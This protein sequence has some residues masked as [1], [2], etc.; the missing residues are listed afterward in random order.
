MRKR[1]LSWK[2][3]YLVSLL[4]HLAVFA[5]LIALLSGAVL[6]TQQ[7]MVVVDLD[8][9]DMP[10]TAG[11][12]H[13]GGGNGG[14]RSPESLFPEKLSDEE[15][16]RRVEQVE[17][18]ESAIRPHAPVAENASAGMPQPAPAQPAGKTVGTAETGSAGDGSGTPDGQGSG[19]GN[20]T[21]EG[22]G[23]GADSGAGNGYGAG[24]GEGQGSGDSGAQGTGRGSFDVAG[25]RAA[26]DANKQYPAMAIRRGLTG[27]VTIAVTLGPSGSC[28]GVSVV[29]SSGQRILDRAAVQAARDACPYP[30]P[31]GRPVQVTTTIHFSLE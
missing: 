13:A 1:V 7:R 11:S 18:A 27:S 23:S 15:M 8:A 24:S 3:A 12:G 14:A 21:S 9:A 25:F 19:A 16:T 22:N 4:I 30:N 2:R 20:G 17:A 6:Q 28:Q 10:E 31:E 29:A 26:I 5:V